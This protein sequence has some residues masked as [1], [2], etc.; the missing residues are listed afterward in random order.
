MRETATFAGGCFWC[1][2]AVF[3]RLKGVE[4][5]IPGYSGGENQNS[6]QEVTTGKTGHAESIQ[7]IF[8]PDILSF[9]ELLLVFFKTHDPT[10]LNRQGADIGPQYRS[11]VFYHNEQ[12]KSDTEKIIQKLN[13]EEVYQNPI[14]TEVS[15]YKSFFEAEDYHKNYYNNNKNAGYC[16]VVINPKLAKLEKEF[17]EKLK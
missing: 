9:K 3:Q 11:A 17:K 12:Q 7:I 5:V 8:N 6:Y 16:Q 14:V 15:E 2:E 4:S 13:E 10:T 1:T